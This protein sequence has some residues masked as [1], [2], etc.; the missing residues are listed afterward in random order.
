[1]ERSTDAVCA[2]EGFITTAAAFFSAGEL[3]QKFWSTRKIRC[4]RPS[5]DGMRMMYL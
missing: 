2:K 1:M 4:D 5:E 3:N